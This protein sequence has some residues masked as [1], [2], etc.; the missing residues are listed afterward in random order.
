M[1][2][3]GSPHPDPERVPTI[4]FVPPPPPPPSGSESAALLR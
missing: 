4:P 1:V 2:S 3:S